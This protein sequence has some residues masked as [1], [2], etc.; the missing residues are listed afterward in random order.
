MF[1]YFWVMNGLFPTT[2]KPNV[3]PRSDTCWAS[4]EAKLN[5][6]MAELYQCVPKSLHKSME[7]YSQF[8]PLVCL[9]AA[10]MLSMLTHV[11]LVSRC[12]QLWKVEHTSQPQGLRRLNFLWS[13]ARS[14]CLHCWACWKE[15]EWAASRTF[16]EAWWGWVYASGPRPVH[17]SL[18]D[19][20]GRLPQNTH[21]G[22]S[23]CYYLLRFQ[24]N[25]QTLTLSV[26][27][28]VL[29]YLGRLCSLGKQRDTQ[30]LGVNV[31]THS[32]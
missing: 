11:L 1:H 8:R 16:K 29:R 7:T 21:H 13:E 12:R 27:L 3:D 23:K 9:I 2:P 4:P 28:S 14:D 22:Q 25:M 32:A 17:E 5:G 30:R 18:C 15:G 24:S 20:S 6:A 19:C 31:G 26:R 10:S